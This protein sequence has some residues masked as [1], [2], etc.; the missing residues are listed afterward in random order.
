M[1]G[2]YAVIGGT[3]DVGT[4]T[5]A[6]AL[7]ASLAEGPRR[8]AVVDAD[9][10]GSALSDAFDLSVDG[11][12]IETVLAGHAALLDATYK[13][14][15]DLA[16]VPGDPDREWHRDANL[17]VAAD[18][19]DVLRRRYDAVLLDVGAGDRPEAMLWAALADEAVF[20]STLDEASLAAT[21]KGRQA[22]EYVGTPVSGVVATRVD[23]GG[24]PDLSAIERRVSAP[25]LAALPRD[26]AAAASAAAGAPV[27]E[28]AP[29]SPTAEAY[30]ELAAR[31]AADDPPS[32]PVVPSPLSEGIDDAVAEPDA[33]RATAE[34]ETPD[35]VGGADGDG[36]GDTAAS[37]SADEDDDDAFDWVGADDSEGSESDEPVSDAVDGP[38]EAVAV[39][40]DGT[41]ASVA[42]ADAERDGMEDE[43]ADRARTDDGDAERDR[44]EDAAEEDEVAAAF[45]E[46]M[47]RVR[48]EREAER[49]DAVEGDGLLGRLF[50]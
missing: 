27:I 24:T 6:A 14:S 48:E 37:E 23:A 47:D 5:T 30:W 12:T 31:I 50:D 46:T 38:A 19:V 11:P 40:A 2:V 28:H 7:G 21:A 35:P 44:A 16:V 25:V 33:A 18:V 36:H 8:V 39:A 22:V 34:A 41:D 9:L 42:D 15:R 26:E 49:D 20:V 4:T 10:S 29:D 13:R 3:D 45:K 1:T 43:D 17:G 32:T